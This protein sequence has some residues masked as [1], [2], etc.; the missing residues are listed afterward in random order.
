[1]VAAA[2]TATGASAASTPPLPS[3][4]TMPAA[5]TGLSLRFVPPRVGPISVD[6]GPT[7]IGGRVM[8]RGLHVATP[9]VSLLPMVPTP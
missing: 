7:I 4:T 3:A 2:V 6:I 5:P 8:D 9:G 1:M